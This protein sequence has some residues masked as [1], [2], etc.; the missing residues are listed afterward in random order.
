MAN[1]EHLWRDLCHAH[2]P[3]S[4]VEELEEGMTWKARYFFLLLGILVCEHTGYGKGGPEDVASYLR[5][6]GHRGTIHPLSFSLSLSPSLSPPLPPP[7]SRTLT[8]S[9]PQRTR[10]L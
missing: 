1:S 4:N 6:L 8:Q 5:D 7:L 10:Y 3:S 9:P 2:F